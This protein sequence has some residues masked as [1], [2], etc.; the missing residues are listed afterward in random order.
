MLERLGTT[1]LEE[2]RETLLWPF[3]N[4]PSL[5]TLILKRSAWDGDLIF[6][7]PNWLR[8]TQARD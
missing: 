5:L 8:D 3:R 4:S 1:E 2:H 6:F 7:I